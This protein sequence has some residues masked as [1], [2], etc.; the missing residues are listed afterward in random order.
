MPV[1]R[2]LDSPQL[3]VL[4][5]E[6]FSPGPGLPSPILER[7]DSVAAF[8]TAR[9]PYTLSDLLSNPYVLRGLAVATVGSIVVW[10]LQHLWIVVL[11]A[12]LAT[13]GTIT[14]LLPRAVTSQVTTLD[15]PHC[16]SSQV[17]HC[18]EECVAVVTHQL[19]HNDFDLL[20]GYS[21]GL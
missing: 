8:S 19:E 14:W 15:T 6:G 18:L 5:L 12:L 21:W 20:I 17:A 2:S 4:Y 13:V 3:R 7:C 16:I 1:D 9:M 10:Q 11:L